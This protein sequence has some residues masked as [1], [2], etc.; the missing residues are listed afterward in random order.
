RGR[1]G[2][3]A[4]CLEFTILCCT[5]TSE[6]TGAKP[7]EFDIAELIWAIPPERMKADKEHRVPLTARAVEIYQGIPTVKGLAFPGSK[8]KELSENTMLKVLERMGYGQYTVHGFRSAFRDWAADQTH[9]PNEVAEMALAHVVDDK[10][11]AA[12]RRGELLDKRRNL[13]N[14]WAAYCASAITA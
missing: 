7:G 10:V 4:A 12:Y 8:G 1:K 3:G 13:A 2:V 5:R 6:S 11:E 9:Y 14:D